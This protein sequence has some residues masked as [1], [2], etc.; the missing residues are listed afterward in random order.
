MGEIPQFWW[1]FTQ[2]LYELLH[3]TVAKG[4]KDKRQGLFAVLGWRLK[5]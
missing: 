3:F 5:R 1:N 2:F 4:Q